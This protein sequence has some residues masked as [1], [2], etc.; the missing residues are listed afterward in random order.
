MHG[1]Q[2]PSRIGGI[3]TLDCIWCCSRRIGRIYERWVWGRF[4]FLRS[5]PV[6]HW[7]NLFYS[8]IV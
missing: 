2:Y 5:A 4:E 8:S 3:K 6:W 7:F 1:V